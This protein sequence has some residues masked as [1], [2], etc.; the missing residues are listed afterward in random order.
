MKP[1]GRTRIAGPPTGHDGPQESALLNLGRFMIL[2]G[3]VNPPFWGSIIRGINKGTLIA[4]AVFSGLMIVFGAALILV[5]RFCIGR[6]IRH[7][8]RQ[9][10]RSHN[11]RR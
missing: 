7:A 10:S 3:L 11:R 6:N 5:G 1:S 2:L 9:E 8:S 4:C